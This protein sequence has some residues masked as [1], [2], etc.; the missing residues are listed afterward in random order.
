MEY[1]G[2]ALEIE[3]W[4]S[5]EE[6]FWLRDA[7]TKH[8]VVIEIGSW[9]GRST[10]ALAE[11]CGSLFFVEHFEGSPT[12]TWNSWYEELFVPDGKAAVRNALLRNLDEFIKS[13][14]AFLIEAKSVEAAAFL[15]PVFMHRQPDMIFVDGDHTYEGFA[16]DLKAWSP[17]FVKP[18]L[19][20]GHDSHLPGVRDALDELLPGWQHG[21]DS[22]WYK[23]DF[24]KDD[25][26]GK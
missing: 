19:F 9:K 10:H 25:L 13:G 20:C 8:P 5:P 23:A 15:R 12:D 22:I 21:E 11:G 16:A 6:L 3:G 26:N 14:K 7:A 1:V 17:Y 2:K 24:T 4:M 18:G